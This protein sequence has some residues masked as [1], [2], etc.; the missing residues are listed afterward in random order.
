MASKL[1]RGDGAFD[2]CFGCGP[3]NPKGLGLVFER[4]GDEIITRVALSADYA[5][6]ET[7]V[8]G[9]I[10][11]SILDEAQGWAMI[12]LADCYGVTRSLNVTYRRPVAVERP[13]VV[14]ATLQERRG[15][16][17]FL[18]SRIEDERGRL[19]ASAAG[20]WITVRSDRAMK[21]ATS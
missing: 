14:R 11:A 2:G 20:H 12:N 13:L 8:H 16:S 10:V 17:V 1:E 18:E 3:G 15:T 5:G 19:L 9:G 6:Y 7:F 4:D 21:R